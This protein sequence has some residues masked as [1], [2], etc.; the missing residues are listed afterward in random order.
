MS[1]VIE[2]DWTSNIEEVVNIKKALSNPC[3]RPIGGSRTVLEGQVGATRLMPKSPI[4]NGLRG[5]R[6]C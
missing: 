1:G 6:T 2:K 3:S 5:I 4:N